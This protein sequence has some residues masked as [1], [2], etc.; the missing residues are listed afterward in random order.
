MV[1]ETGGFSFKGMCR[2]HGGIAVP[3]WFPRM[4]GS[5]AAAKPSNARSQRIRAERTLTRPKRCRIWK[6]Q[7]Q[8]Q[9]RKPWLV[10]A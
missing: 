1:R 10:R 3:R 9:K 5:K 8:T 2:N 4:A 7:R 6:G